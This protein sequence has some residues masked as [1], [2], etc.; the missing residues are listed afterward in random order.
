MSRA[1]QNS[2]TVAV[3]EAHRFDEA[4]LERWMAANVSGYGGPLTVEQFKGGQSNPTYRL[5]TPGRRYVLRRKPPGKLLPGA[6][7]VDREYRV[8]A[9]LHAQGFPVAEPFGLCTDEAVIGTPFYV[10][11]MVEGRIFWDASL[12]EVPTGERA[13]YF[14]AMNATIAALHAIDPEAAGLGEVRPSARAALSAFTSIPF[15]VIV[16]MIVTRSPTLRPS[17]FASASRAISHRSLPFCTAIIF[18]LI[19]STG[20]VTW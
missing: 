9:A 6:H 12:P 4:A 18:S 11:D 15:A 2:G 3:R 20:P 19:S 17:A 1:E 8:I 10:M 14:D 5:S 7:A 13:R 16:Y